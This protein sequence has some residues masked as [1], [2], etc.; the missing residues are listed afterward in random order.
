MKKLLFFAA[1]TLVALASCS[2]EDIVEQNAPKATADNVLSIYPT[3]AGQTRGTAWDN[4]NFTEFK[5]TTSGNFQEDDTDVNH[6]SGAPFD[7]ETVKKQDDG[8]WLVMKGGTTATEY[9]WPS[10]SA[11]SDF[12]AWAPID[13]GNYIANAE[14]LT[15]LEDIVVAY[16]K[17]D[18]STFATG[19]PL[20]FRHITSQIIVKAD[21][22]ASNKI[23]IKVKGIRLNNIKNT[24]KWALPSAAVMGT[25]TTV[26]ALNYDP[27]S[28]LDGAADYTVTLADGSEKTLTASATDFT[29]SKPLFL[30]PQ[31]LADATESIKDNTNTDGQYLSV[32]VQ[33]QTI[34]TTVGATPEAVYPKVGDGETQGYA[35]AAVDIN[36]LWE[37]GKKYIYTLHFKEDGYG[38]IDDNQ[39]G[40]GT[41]DPDPEKKPGDDVVDSP[42]KLVLDVEVMGWEE[43][44]ESQDM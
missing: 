39:E 28:A 17:G 31:Q 5:L 27:W 7:G 24:G 35:W 10:K 14:N 18:A 26:D 22:Q 1:T 11:S 37:P 40:G 13:A 32:L 12:V 8:S 29:G 36:T 43:V 2:S 19:V 16:N 44:T 33:I 3:V 41:E 30:I 25:K 23:Q 6:A 34:A 42:V 38:K 21:N 4:S 9:Y 20:K 15:E